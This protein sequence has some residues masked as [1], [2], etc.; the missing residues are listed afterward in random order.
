MRGSGIGDPGSSRFVVLF[1]ALLLAACGKTTQQAGPPVPFDEDGACP[2]QCCT[3]REWSVEYPTDV[4]GDRRDQ[5]PI[6]FHVD[7]NDT[8][9]A[10]TG[11]VT[12]TKIGRAQASRDVHVGASHVLV[13]AGQ[14]IYL[15]RNVGGGDWKIWVGGVVDRQYIPSQGYCTPEKQSSDECAITVVDQPVNVWWAKVS[16]T[17]GQMGWTREVDHFGNID[18][19]E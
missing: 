4:H 6:A 1:A 8:V 3:Y 9:N 15:I 19:C 2:F 12:T 7:A 10:T 5:S 18:A 17:R 13:P 11:V 14:P 16:N